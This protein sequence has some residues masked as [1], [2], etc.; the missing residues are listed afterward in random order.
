[1][2]PVCREDWVSTG[3]MVF[4][5]LSRRERGKSRR[6]SLEN[7]RRREEGEREVV[8]RS[9]GSR[10]PEVA[11]YSS[12]RAAESAARSWALDSSN[13]KSLRSWVSLAMSLGRGCWWWWWSGLVVGFQSM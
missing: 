2:M 9:L 11:V 13:L 3:K 12:S 6:S 1:M 8:M 4:P 5:L 7:W 10:R